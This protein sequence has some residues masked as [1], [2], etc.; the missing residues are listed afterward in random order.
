[1]A[2]LFVEIRDAALLTAAVATPIALWMWST[3]NI[4]DRWSRTKHFVVSG[5]LALGIAVAIVGIMLGSWLWLH[6][7]LGA[8]FWVEHLLPSWLVPT[9]AIGFGLIAALWL[10]RLDL[11]RDTGWCRWEAEEEWGR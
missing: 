8:V 5:A 3:W 10:A 2:S 11:R 6:F 9:V 7:S 1:L 4:N